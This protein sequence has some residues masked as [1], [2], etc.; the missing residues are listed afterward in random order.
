MR[1]LLVGPL[2]PPLASCARILG[3]A[4]LTAERADDHRAALDLLAGG[5]FAAVVLGE[6]IEGL[7]WDVV[8]A[9]LRAV[10]AAR[11]IAAAPT[12]VDPA[13]RL[14]A[15]AAGVY[16]LVERSGQGHSRHAVAL[17]DAVMKALEPAEPPAALIV[18]GCPEVIRI[19]AEL[20][21][22]EGCRVDVATSTAQ[23]VRMMEAR[24]YGL[25]V[26][27]TRRAGGDGFV[28]VR[29]A[30][31]LRPAAPVVVLTASPDD[32][33]FLRS[34]ELG[35]RACLW[36]LDEPGLIARAIRSAMRP[37]WSDRPRNRE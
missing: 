28:V 17:A 4:G 32:Q 3:E 15:Y 26:T 19:L 1:V 33:T 5:G 20:I 35:A 9:A 11:V 24:D 8:A 7:A 12:P 22:E 27:E 16:D 18:D 37:V 29:E 13:M 23:A 6:Q 21:A 14:R 31:R 2:G 10:P 34:V 25:I 30:A 36:K